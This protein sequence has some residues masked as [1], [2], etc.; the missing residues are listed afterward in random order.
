MAVLHFKK[1]TSEGNQNAVINGRAG[2]YRTLPSKLRG[3]PPSNLRTASTGTRPGPPKS[4][5]SLG[6]SSI[7]AGGK[8]NYS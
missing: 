2:D 6:G 8:H 3:Q 5:S 1:S 7:D 4:S